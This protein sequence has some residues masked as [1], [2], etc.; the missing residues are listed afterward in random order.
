MQH[1]RER[2]F[3]RGPCDGLNTLNELNVVLYETKLQL[4]TK[5][6]TRVRRFRVVFR[7]ANGQPFN[8]E[9]LGT[10]S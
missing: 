4:G 10:E 8:K 2:H 5:L 3:D 9:G 7:T 1:F 6:R